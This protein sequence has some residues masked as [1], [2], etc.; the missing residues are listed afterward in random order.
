MTVFEK[1]NEFMP[2]GVTV[3]DVVSPVVGHVGTGVSDDV[4]CF[5][6]SKSAFDLAEDGCFREWLLS[7]GFD[8]VVLPDW[9]ADFWDY[10]EVISFILANLPD[11]EVIVRNAKL[12]AR[13]AALWPDQIGA[14]STSEKPHLVSVCEGADAYEAP[15]VSVDMEELNTV[16]SE[17]QLPES[18]SRVEARLG[19]L[20]ASA[21]RP[22]PDS[23]SSVP[24]LFGHHD[25]ADLLGQG[26]AAANA[27]IPEARLS[28]PAGL[29]FGGGYVL[30]A[31]AAGEEYVLKHVDIPEFAARKTADSATMEVP[32]DPRP[33]KILKHETAHALYVGQDGRVCVAMSGLKMLGTGTRHMYFATDCS[34]FV[35]AT[36]C[37]VFNES[38]R[39]VGIG[40]AAAPTPTG[41]GVAI[42]VLRTGALWGDLVQQADLGNDF[43]AEA[44]SQLEDMRLQPGLGPKRRN[45]KKSRLAS[46]ARVGG[47]G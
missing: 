16:W 25:A 13:L 22:H 26:A 15:E 19:H 35:P 8:L 4:H 37:F 6:S 20:R 36:G 44:L 29:H 31:G 38:W 7:G 5:A 2:D 34:V 17:R 40:V 9:D 30:S 11:A 42:A 32:V 47:D 43:A 18:P 27:V 3:A 10:R 21:A 24:V 12:Q 14:V 23:V 39:F 1:C 33:G 45:E 41:Q 28:D 46:P